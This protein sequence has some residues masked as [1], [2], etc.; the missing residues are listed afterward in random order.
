M[1]ILINIEGIVFQICGDSLLLN[2]FILCNLVI[3]LVIGLKCKY[4]QKYYWV[5]FSYVLNKNINVI[6]RM[7]NIKKGVY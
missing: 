5:G 7:L 1:S 4:F 6:F 2:K 3:I